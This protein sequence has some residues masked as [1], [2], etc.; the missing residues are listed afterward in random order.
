MSNQSG[1]RTAA[2]TGGQQRTAP[3]NSGQQR[4]TAP[5]QRSQTAPPPNIQS[6]Q[7]Q[8]LR[9]N[10]PGEQVPAPPGYGRF[11]LCKSCTTPHPHLGVSVTYRPQLRTDFIPEMSVSGIKS[12]WRPLLRPGFVQDSHTSHLKIRHPTREKLSTTSAEKL[13]TG[14][15][16]HR[17]IYSGQVIHTTI[18][19]PYLCAK[20]TFYAE[21]QQHTKNP[22]PIGAPG[23]NQG[24]SRCHRPGVR[25]WRLYPPC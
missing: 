23:V 17:S 4:A 14:Y 24:V 13:S 7:G 22:A 25:P 8:H 9:H 2:G 21:M 18:Y 20:D 12:P 3:D 11:R 19:G 16:Q 10:D 5:N 15:P 6:E 1:G